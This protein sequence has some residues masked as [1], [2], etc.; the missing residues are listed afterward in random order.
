VPDPVAAGALGP[1]ARERALAHLDGSEVDVL[2]VGGGVVGAGVALDAATRGLSVALVEARDLAAGT[3]SRSS[4]LIHGGVRYLEQL[5]LGLV[6]EAL[7]ERELL[8]HTLAPH[9]VRPVP[10]VYPLTHRVW[11]RPYVGAGLFLYDRLGGAGA[12]PAHRHLSRR[13]LRTAVPGLRPDVAVGGLQYVDAQ[14]DDARHTLLLARTAAA[15]GAH[16]VTGAPVVGLRRGADGSVTGAQVLDSLSGRTL[17][18]RA[19]HVVSAAGVWSEEVARMVGAAGV[20]MRASK[21]VHVTVPREAIDSTSGLITRTD[22]SVLFVIP[23][24]RH[25]L[26][27]TTDTPWT[28]DLAH[29]VATRADVD[30]VLG[31][32]NRWLARPLGRS[33][34]HGVIAGLRPLLDTGAADT[35]RLSR[36]HAVVRP[37]P[38]LSVVAGGKYTTYRVMA[39]DA[40]DV[41]A[42][43]LGVDTRSRTADVPLLGAAGV[44]RTPA[45]RRAWSAGAGVDART[46][47]HLLSRHGTLASDVLALVRDRPELAEPVGGD[48]LAAEVVHAARTEAVLHLDDVLTRRTR[49]ALETPDRGA[50]ALEPV[51]RLVAGELGWDERRRSQEVASY[52]ARLRAEQ[53]AEGA[54]D[55]AA[56]SRER[57]AWRD[58]RLLAA[59]G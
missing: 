35:A 41:A 49:L 33:D 12:V 24:K 8:L 34:V 46:G 5:Q 2:V 20:R 25:W 10:F 11:E 21:G 14:V 38:G 27:G 56:A 57:S 48:Y 16:V 40:V 30:F 3:S 7:R 39:A 28:Q 53:A 29:P 15:H 9:L 4:K 50:A 32:A 44:P 54:A 19:R 47:E 43:E 1:A 42:A 51:A 17:E 55:D 37:V 59:A 45:E 31:Q 13:G 22:R 18:V 23:W 36:E 52:R 6:R 26:I 58:P